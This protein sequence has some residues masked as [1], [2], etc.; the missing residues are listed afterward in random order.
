MPNA[1]ECNGCTKV[2]IIVSTKYVAQV[3]LQS[4]TLFHG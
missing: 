1:L 3:V 2:A 4:N